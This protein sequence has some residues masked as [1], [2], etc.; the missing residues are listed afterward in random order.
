MLAVARTGWIPILA[1]VSSIDVDY[2]VVRDPDLGAAP[3][4]G[5]ARMLIAADLGGTRLIDNTAITLGES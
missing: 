3:E 5:P 4:V 1:D 2:L